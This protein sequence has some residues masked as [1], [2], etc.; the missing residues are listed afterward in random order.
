MNISRIDSVEMGS[1]YFRIE[2]E[3]Q[4]CN[5]LY[6]KGGDYFSFERN[7]YGRGCFVSLEERIEGKDVF[8]VRGKNWGGVDDVSGNKK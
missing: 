6:A 4:G 2:E 8:D 1:C 5:V 7:K 3:N